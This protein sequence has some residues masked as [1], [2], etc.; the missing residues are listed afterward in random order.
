[1][2]GFRGGVFASCVLYLFCLRLPLPYLSIGDL[3]MRCSYHTVPFSRPSLS[4]FPVSIPTPPIPFV[5]GAC[6]ARVL[7]VPFLAFSPSPSRTV[8]IPVLLWLLP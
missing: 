6:I 8:H 2:P 5:F 1:M 3:S 7:C 4:F